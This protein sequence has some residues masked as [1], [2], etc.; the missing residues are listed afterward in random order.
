MWNTIKTLALGLLREDPR[1]QEETEASLLQWVLDTGYAGAPEPHQHVRDLIYVYAA[2]LRNAGGPGPQFEPFAAMVAAAAES[3]IANNLVEEV[4]LPAFAQCCGDYLDS[5]GARPLAAG[6]T[7][8]YR[9]QLRQM[10]NG[11][12]VPGFSVLQSCLQSVTAFVGYLHR[13]YGGSVLSYHQAFADA[14]AETAPNAFVVE[15]YREIAGFPRVGVAVGMNFFKDSQVPSFRNGSLDDL[16]NHHVGWFAKPDKHVL[17]LMLHATGRTSSAG[18]DCGE[19]FRL[20][21]SL[22]VRT[23]SLELPTD[24]GPYELDQGQPGSERGAWRCVEDIHRLAALEG[25]APLGFDRLIYLLGSGRYKDPNLPLVVSQRERYRRFVQAIDELHAGGHGA[26]GYGAVGGSAQA[27]LLPEPED[28]RDPIV[29]AAQPDRPSA[30]ECFFDSISDS[31]AALELVEQVTACCEELD[32]QLHHT[33][34][35]DGDLRVR[36]DRPTP[37]PREQNIITMAWIPTKGYFSCQALLHPHE[38]IEQG[39]PPDSVRPNTDPLASRLNVR[40][41]VDDGAFLS[42]VDLSVQRFRG[43]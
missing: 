12:Q 32:A 40:P 24:A 39:M 22:A 21:D 15:K 8:D 1:Y 26:G 34:T 10:A 3:F 31:E 6:G 23:Y 11:N 37:H 17:R 13:E 2:S 29:V 14:C 30:A 19:L 35:H 27:V 20:P 42:I 7:R 38:C 4:T 18:I 33:H 9:D 28:N 41:G 16:L 36:A 25:I 43:L 5:P